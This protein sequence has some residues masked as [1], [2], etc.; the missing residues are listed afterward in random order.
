[1]AENLVQPDYSHE[2]VVHTA[3]YYLFGHNTHFHLAQHNSLADAE[4]QAGKEKALYKRF[5][6]NSYLEFITIIRKLFAPGFEKDREILASFAP[7][8]IEK[9]F[10]TFRTG[11][12][13]DYFEKEIK[14]YFK[15]DQGNKKLQ[16]ALSNFESAIQSIGGSSNVKGHLIE[17]QIGF[18][19]DAVGPIKKILND[20]YSEQLHY[21]ND[22]FTNTLQ[23]IL[24]E[25][26][27]KGE[28]NIVHNLPGNEITELTHQIAIANFPWGYKLND[29]R[30]AIADPR[31][32]EA[33]IFMKAMY[34]VEE[35]IMNKC[36]GG[37]QDLKEAALAVYDKKIGNNPLNFRFFTG[38]GGKKAS[39]LKA[40]KGSLGEFQAAMMF[41]Y[42]SRRLG[43]TKNITTIVGNLPARG[44]ELGKADLSLALNQIVG[45]QVKNW[46]EYMQHEIGT[47]IHPI[48][49]A[50][51]MEDGQD[52]LQFIANIYFNTSYKAGR[53][54]DLNELREVINSRFQELQNHDV[55]AGLTDKVSFYLIEGKYLVP[56]SELLKLVAGDD[57][58]FP[59]ENVSIT[60][61]YKGKSDMAYRELTANKENIWWERNEEGVWKPAKENEKTFKN[62]VSKS[63]SIRTKMDLSGKLSKYNLLGI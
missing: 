23:D 46:N 25:K 38:A 8:S 54:E 56:C 47:T 19:S 5:G 26:M 28:I 37:S 61:S 21:N 9:D 40:I 17:I 12:L 18:N 6:A 11:A 49:F 31:S 59:K 51:T 42:F 45:V 1:M 15:N 52:F 35:F 55:V 39:M 57:G 34:I 32:E 4:V 63:I 60:S 2:N 7:E 10:E 36:S 44:S 30:A 24:A 33:K 43:T 3:A 48:E 20:M 62:L 13:S 16:K 29:I 22:S 27:N 41:E 53:E 50:K 58:L 14:I